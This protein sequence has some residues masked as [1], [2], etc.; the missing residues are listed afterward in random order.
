MKTEDN[1]SAGNDDYGDS[2]CDDHSDDVT[3]DDF[4]RDEKI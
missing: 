4:P 3:T 1:G 2:G